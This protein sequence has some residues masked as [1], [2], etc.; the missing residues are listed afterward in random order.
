VEGHVSRRICCWDLAL[1]YVIVE[2]NELNHH[3]QI[4]SWKIRVNLGR[5]ISIYRAIVPQST[6]AHEHLVTWAPW[7]LGA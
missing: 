6:Q 7:H 4:N 2:M 1:G 3:F 5:V